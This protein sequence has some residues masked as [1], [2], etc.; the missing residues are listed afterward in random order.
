MSCNTTIM[1][2][3]RERAKNLEELEQKV[4]F[5]QVN[6]NKVEKVILTVLNSECQES[7]GAEKESVELALANA[8]LPDSSRFPLRSEELV[9]FSFHSLWS[10]VETG[11]F[12]SSWQAGEKKR[13][14]NKSKGS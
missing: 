11:F 8:I 10:Q 1:Q 3:R 7:L 2:E 9:G 6:A 13:K 12:S 5:L 14:G 4:S